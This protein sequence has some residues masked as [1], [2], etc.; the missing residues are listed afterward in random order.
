VSV[1][2]IRGRAAQQRALAHQRDADALHLRTAG[3]NF[4]VIGRQLGVTASAAQKAYK[5][6]IERLAPIAEREEGRRLEAERLDQLQIP[7]WQKAL[8]GDTDALNAVLSIMSR[9]ARL[10]GLDAPV[11]V[12]VSALLKVLTELRR[13]PE[14]DLLELLGYIAEGGAEAE[15]DGP[16]ALP[17]HEE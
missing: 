8:A 5:R 7:H 2:P 17:P 6:A 14:G 12:H 1:R 3:A 11:E 15:Q 13:L 9:R 10:L 16:A 4:E